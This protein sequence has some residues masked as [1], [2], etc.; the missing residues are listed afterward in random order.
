MILIKLE[1]PFLLFSLVLFLLLLNLLIPCLYLFLSMC[2]HETKRKTR[3][4]VW[5]LQVVYELLWWRA[6]K[7]EVSSLGWVYYYI[8]TFHQD[9]R[10]PS[11]TK[12]IACYKLSILHLPLYLYPTCLT[13]SNPISPS[14]RPLCC[15]YPLISRVDFGSHCD[16]T[17]TGDVLGHLLCFFKLGWSNFG[18]KWLFMS[19]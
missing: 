11:L 4:L 14:Y 3:S 9:L 17:S 10:T 13:R 6:F 7:K 15:C 1:D 19:G 2:C 12:L 18:N 16:D 5:S 8:S